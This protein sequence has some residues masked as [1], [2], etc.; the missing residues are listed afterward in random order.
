MSLNLLAIQDEITAKLREIPQDVY[1]TSAP[2]D[3]KLKFDPN[4]N[5]LP[6]VVLE[7]SD[8][9]EIGLGN[10][11]VGSKYNLMQS[12]VIASCIGPTERSTRQVADVVRNKL[13]GFIPAD[14]GE[15]RLAVGSKV[16][17][18]QDVRPN[19]YTTEVAFIFTANTVW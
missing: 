6:Y 17:T 2:D 8:M 5:I 7:F 14:A 4:G 18:L 15:L 16:F 12:Y 19:R 11:I 13:T 3:S 10:G 9:Q 1:E